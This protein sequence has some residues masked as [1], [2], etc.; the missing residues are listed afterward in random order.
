MIFKNR[1]F[2]PLN[3]KEK[4]IREILRILLV[5]IFSIIIKGIY[6]E[7]NRINEDHILV[8]I[9][10]TAGEVFFIL[11][12]INAFSSGNLVRRWVNDSV[13]TYIFNLIQ[14]IRKTNDEMTMKLSTRLLGI[15]GFIILIIIILWELNF[16]FWA[17][18]V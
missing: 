12:V 18:S 17:K 9:C 2:Y 10:S 3:N 15:F 8:P 6:N 13:L 14:T 7:S 4:I 5:I 1:E 16:Y 11:Y